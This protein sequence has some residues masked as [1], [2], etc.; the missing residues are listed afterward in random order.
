[1]KFDSARAIGTVAEFNDPRFTAD[2]GEQQIAG[3]VADRLTSV[4]WRAEQRQVSG[5]KFAWL[6]A[7]WIGWLGA[8]VL[9]TAATWVIRV[10]WLRWPL[11]AWCSPAL[12]VWGVWYVNGLAGGLRLGCKR[13]PRGVAPLIVA[14]R[15]APAVPACRVVLATPIGPVSALPLGSSQRDPAVVGAILSLLFLWSVLFAP[16]SA[17]IVPPA[18]SLTRELT[19]PAIVLLGL[20][21]LFV[22]AQAVRELRLSRSQEMLEPTDRTGI[23]LLL[24]IARTW[25]PPRDSHCDLVVAST[26]GQTLDF[27]GARS[28]LRELES[29]QERVPTLFLFLFAPGAGEITTLSR[30]CGD[31]AQAA[32]KS[33]WIPHRVGPSSLQRFGLLPPE[34]SARELVALLGTAALHRRGKRAALDPAALGAYAQLATEIALRWAKRRS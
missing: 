6:A 23:A 4:G 33:L 3:F 30:N 8:A 25:S 34:S 15:E 20:F 29:G 12:I 10:S 28:L 32:A 19:Q 18:T 1:M 16:S 14:H 22:G 11:P 7:S 2:G 27:A 31:L 17:R 26:G 24:E 5:S 13:P 21:W 9:A